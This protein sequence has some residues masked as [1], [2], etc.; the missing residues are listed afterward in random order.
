[1]QQGS[2]LPIVLKI[3]FVIFVVEGLIMAGLAAID[4]SNA[5]LAAL[6]DAALLTLVSSYWICQWV[7]RPYVQERDQAEDDLV[8]YTAEMENLRLASL[9]I[10]DGGDAVA[11]ASPD[12]TLIAINTGFNRLTGY[13][14]DEIVRR[15]QHMFN[16]G[17]HSAAFYK[18]LWHTVSVTGKWQGEMW[19]PHRGGTIFPA[20][21]SVT[22]LYNSDRSA[23]RRLIR[24]SDVTSGKKAQELKWRH[25][26][27]DHITGL[28]NRFMFLD[29]L[30]WSLKQA[31][32]LERP[33]TLILVDIDQFH[34]VNE[35]HG[36]AVGDQLLKAVGERLVAAV[37]ATDTVARLG[38]DGYGL[39]LGELKDAASREQLAQSLLEKLAEPYELDGAIF[40]LTASIG[41][42]VYPDDGANVH[43][44]LK[45]ATQARED[46][47]E[48][49]G[50][51]LV[52]S[53]KDKEV[54]ETES[55]AKFLAS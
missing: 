29:R 16:T 23:H 47:K 3:G 19:L 21:V 36:L 28:P 11:V 5:R 4:I 39:I 34:H 22:S 40:K 31:R 2:R 12:G 35:M 55:L 1:M 51:A 44:L 7:I 30:Q 43:C 13:T 42:S 32:Q 38:E 41:V 27:F 49:G 50:N 18:S 54:L 25:A 45:V 46:A 52:G 26:N 15:K 24:V 10:D 14:A 53:F 33:L 6:A 20:W 48:M 37:G 9:V 17:S 8:R